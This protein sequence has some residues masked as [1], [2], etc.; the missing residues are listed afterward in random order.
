[1]T[2]FGSL[3]AG[4]GGFDLGLERAGMEC[5]WQVEIDEYCRRVLA[6]HWPTVP[7]LADVRDVS[8]STVAAVDGICGGFP[9]QPVS[10]AGKRQGASDSRWLWPEFACV[11]DGLRPRWVLLENVPGLLTQQDGA[12][13]SVTADLAA[14]GYDAEWG[15]VSASAF[16]APYRRSRWFCV[17][18]DDRHGFSWGTEQ[19]F[20]SFLAE[21]E[22][23]RW[24]HFERC[25]ED[26][27]NSTSIGRREGR[28]EPAGQQR[29]HNGA[30]I[31]SKSDKSRLEERQGQSSDSRTERSPFVGTGWWIAEPDVVR[32]VPGFPG[33]VDRIRALGNAVVPQVAEYIG[34]KI[35]ARELEAEKRNNP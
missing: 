12:G 15:C 29:R 1:M 34:K 18:Y 25:G 22:S 14:L 24:G 11:V 27:P 33:R 9:C 13:A 31:S 30:S 16:G 23:S 5:K 10:L 7:R 20:Q 8:A 26:G 35:L 3:F 4:I 17:A 28:T 2:T 6:K 19:D 32:V 21:F